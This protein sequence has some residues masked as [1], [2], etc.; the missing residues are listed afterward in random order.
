[1]AEVEW[2]SGKISESQPDCTFR[3]GKEDMSRK[4]RMSAHPTV[5]TMLH[6]SVRTCGEQKH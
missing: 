2:I 4:K 3:S 1:M 6:S 5:G